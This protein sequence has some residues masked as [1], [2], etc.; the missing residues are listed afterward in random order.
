[1]QNMSIAQKGARNAR[2]DEELR[3]NAQVFDEKKA[4]LPG[5]GK[6]DLPLLTIVI[7]LLLFGLIMLFSA[8]YPNGHLRYGD[9]YYYISDQLLFGAIGIGGMIFA[10]LVDYRLLKKFAWPIMVV[11]LILLVV[12]LFMPS[13]NGANRWIWLNGSRTQSVQPSE[14]AKF[15]LIAVFAK[16]IHANQNKIRTFMYGFLPFV[17]VLGSV[18]LLLILEPHLSCTILVLGVGIFMMFTGGTPIRYF[19]LALAVGAVAVFLV[20]TLF[21]SAIPYALG[22]IN[23]WL[24]PLS[25]DPADSHQII[26]S[27]I[28][29]GSGG[30]LGKGIGKSVQKFLYLPEVHNDYIFAMICEELGMVGAIIVMLLFLAL[31][32]RGIFVA[33]RAKD[34][35]GSMLVIGI[36]VQIALQA[37]LHIAVNLNAIPSTGI[38]LPFFSSGGTSLIMLLSEVG[39]VLSVS[40]KARLAR[41]RT[42]RQQEEEEA[43]LIF[44]AQEQARRRA[45][46]ERGSA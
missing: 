17:L 38:A 45:M 21:P 7:V 26:Q 34:K 27:L 20:L 2:S 15:A 36:I 8:S 32:A 42:K 29:V 43:L 37:F 40:R 22:R 4:A 28:A 44:E 5:I 14:I 30:V 3:E 39:V 24:H 18:A 10:S 31:L 25:A 6:I 33:M 41:G 19:L 13:N 46:S 9:S 23:T 35:F 16:M 11:S 1:M 12:V